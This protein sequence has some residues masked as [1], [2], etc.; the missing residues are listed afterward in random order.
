[1]LV[2]PLWP[3]AV[4]II[5]Y[6]YIVT[7]LCE[8]RDK[9]QLQCD[10]KCYLTKMFAEKSTENHENPFAEGRILEIPLILNTSATATA[11]QLSRQL[12]QS[13]VVDDSYLDMTTFLF[14][15]EIVQPPEV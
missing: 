6:D 13:Q 9:P 8:N 1:M 11:H 3:L 2:K 10:G 4:Y 14:V 5:N 7:N 15:F 12:N